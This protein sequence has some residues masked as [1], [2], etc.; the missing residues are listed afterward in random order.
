MRAV[1]IV[2]AIG[3]GDGQCNPF[4][5]SSVDPAFLQGAVE[6][7]IPFQRGR[8]VANQA[9]HIWRGAEHFFD[10]FQQSLACLRGV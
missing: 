9:E 2:A 5:C 3:V 6:A 8:A 10:A 1:A 7:E 4:A